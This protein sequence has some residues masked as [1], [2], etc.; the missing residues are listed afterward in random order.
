[1]GSQ[2]T[3]NNEGEIGELYCEYSLMVNRF[4]FPETMAGTVTA[5]VYAHN[6]DY[7]GTCQP[8]LYYDLN[9]MPIVRASAN[10]GYVDIAVGGGK[11]PGWRSAPLSNGNP[12][13]AGRALWFG[14][15]SQWFNPRFDY[16][17]KCYW[18]DYYTQY[19]FDTPLPSLF[20]LWRPDWYYDF[21][22]SMYLDYTS[23]Q[24]YTRTLTQ[25]VT[26]TDS[27]KL[28]GAYK[29]NATQT[30]W[31]TTALGRFKGFFINLVQTAG[32]TMTLKASPTL[33]R[34]LIQ[35]AGAGDT[36]QRFL[37]FLWKAA[38]TAWINSETE[39]ITQVKRSV[40]DTGKSET[41]ID[42][43]Q[44]AKRRIAHT[45]N[46][47]AA[48]LKK[49]EYVKRFQETAG[50][51]GYAGAVRKLAVRLIEAVAGLYSMK[52]VS[53]FGR[54]IADKAGIGSGMGGMVTFF[55][56]LFGLGG[57]GDS[58]G[59]FITRMR[60]IQD[61]ETI[62]DETGHTADYL[63]GLFVEAGNM[64]ETTHT[65]EYHRKQQDTA[66]SEAV[67]LRHLFVFI[68]LVTGAYIRELIIGRFLKSNEELVLKSCICREITLD[69]GL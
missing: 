53:G 68:R 47:G 6:T 62:E 24:N 33:I 46:A 44:D 5:Y 13:P 25:G 30:V 39:P 36:V 9:D 56:T 48:V 41:A 2:Y 40:T 59:N 4:V 43:K 61:T 11:S 64:A 52:A 57:S 63:R 1:V 29:R 49:A 18:D 14:F 19:G 26:L 37:S 65:G 42:R 58:T 32:S 23:S 69:S 12:I 34:K 15:T 60:V 35:Q 8:V 28:I 16:G 45:G 3:W 50:S 66:Y 27:R 7:A 21:K 17:A 10:E 31:G 22:L 54:S 20:P 51:T 38:Y 67:P 55:R